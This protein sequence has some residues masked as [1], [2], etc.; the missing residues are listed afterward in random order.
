MDGNG[1]SL[2]QELVAHFI[3]SCG[4]FIMNQNKKKA[5]TEY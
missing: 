5:L 2:L 3:L 1:H 4:L